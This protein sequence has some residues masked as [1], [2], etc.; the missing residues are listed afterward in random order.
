MVLENTISN[1][2]LRALVILVLVFIALKIIVFV[3]GKIILRI[4]QKTKTTLDDKIVQ[5]SSKPISFLILIIGLRIAFLELPITNSLFDITSKVITSILILA[6]FFLVYRIID[7]F[8]TNWGYRWAKRTKSTLDDSL[9]GLA[10]K[11]LIVLTI[12]IA[13]LYLLNFWGVEITP[14]LA[15][16]GIAGIAVA[17]ALQSSL[18]NIFGGI[19]LILDKTIKV[20]DLIY[21]DQET[22]GTVMDVGLRSTK[23]RTFDNEVVIMP[24]GKL[25][26]MRIQNVVLPDAKVRVVIPFSVAYGSNIDKVKEIAL[27]EILKIGGIAKDS[28]LEPFVRFTEM[29]DSSLLFKAYF[30]MEDYSERFR[31]IDEANTRIYNALNKNKITIPFPQLDVHLKKK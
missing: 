8:I 12:I 27:K 1:D 19:S 30:F 7:I 25:A 28:E 17:F 24:N 6:I 16:L 22:R 11:S 21:I 18:A 29:R 3:I 9:F 5:K 14:L 23:I 20:G 2:Y 4:T 15:S 31:A 10:H 26:D 13:F